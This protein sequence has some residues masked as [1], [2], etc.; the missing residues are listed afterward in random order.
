MR[1]PYL[2][3]ICVVASSAAYAQ[4]EA[5]DT[6]PPPETPTAVSAEAVMAPPPPV[7]AP[8]FDTGPL[9]VEFHGYA[10]QG[11]VISDHNNYY[12]SNTNRGSARLT[13]AALN[14]TA[15]V[16]DKL[17]IVMQIA[18]VLNDSTPQ[19]QLRID[20]G[21]A[22]YHFS[23]KLGVRAGRFR[24]LASLYSEVWDTDIARVPIFLP[25]SVYDPSGRQLF[26]AADGLELYGQL[27]SA[28]AGSINYVLDA[29]V[30]D[31]FTLNGLTD[32]FKWIGNSRI[33]YETP[34]QGLRLGGSLTLVGANTSQQLDP[35]TTA[36]LIAT[37]AAPADF[38]G[39]LNLKFK[40]LWVTKE[41]IEYAFRGLTVTAE[42]QRI[43][44][45]L[46]PQG[47]AIPVSHLRNEGFYGMVTYRWVDWFTTGAYASFYYPDYFGR[48]TK[49][50]AHTFDYAFTTR[51]DINAYL[52]F[53]MEVHR[54]DGT[55]QLVNTVN[56]H[57]ATSPDG[58]LFAA[59]AS[60]AF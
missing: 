31:N 1:T 22:D 43:H 54:I 49:A 14:A 21:F 11:Y 24:L 32:D 56:P 9:P 5:P 41:F 8:V 30:L 12:L 38:N 58:W 18:A 51:F 27:D 52:A 55:S 36:G 15:Q 4:E 57:G 59:R 35:G 37:G 44:A 33:I 46:V 7:A 23:D 42:Y 17:R 50:A 19:P 34:I 20:F 45:N 53:K 10:S 40:D 47:V 25:S 2:S 28:A 6:T 60:A 29:A 48:S 3:L 39:L 16:T 13:D 26:L